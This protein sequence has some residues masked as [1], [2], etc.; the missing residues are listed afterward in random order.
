[1][2]VKEFNI[3]DNV[4]VAGRVAKIID[5]SPASSS[6]EGLIIYY[7]RFTS[8]EE[9]FMECSPDYLQQAIKSGCIKLLE[10]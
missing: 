9:N 8:G 7:F 4:L 6:F 5:I 1:M 2:S 3:G 10:E